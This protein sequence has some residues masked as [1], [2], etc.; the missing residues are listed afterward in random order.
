[1]LKPFALDNEGR[2]SACFRLSCGKLYDIV[3][4]GD[5]TGAGEDMDIREVS[6]GV[7]SGVGDCRRT[8]IG[9]KGSLCG[10]GDISRSRSIE[11]T[12]PGEE[13]GMGGV[14]RLPLVTSVDEPKESKH[15]THC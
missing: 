7:G 9:Q 3:S 6:E 10:R 11:S 14:V 8:G 13:E 5:S 2:R 1:V 15:S 12:T 4:D